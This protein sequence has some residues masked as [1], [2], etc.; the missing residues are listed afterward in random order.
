MIFMK[1][2]IG[3]SKDGDRVFSFDNSFS[4]FKARFLNKLSIEVLDLK[5][6]LSR[7]KVLRELLLMIF[8]LK[9]A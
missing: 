6:V 2:V 5:Y 1:S 4:F 3:V 9:K 8:S 7:L